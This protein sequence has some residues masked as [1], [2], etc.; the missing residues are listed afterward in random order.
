MDEKRGKGHHRRRARL[1]GGKEEGGL[2]S[3]TTVTK[4]KQDIREFL[5]RADRYPEEKRDKSL[6]LL[7]AASHILSP[8]VSLSLSHPSEP[9]T[10]N[11]LEP[12]DLWTKAA[13]WA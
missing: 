7:V 12:P 4:V 6:L 1:T 8:A 11:E 13:A 9:V 2:A 5:S 10:D 3:A